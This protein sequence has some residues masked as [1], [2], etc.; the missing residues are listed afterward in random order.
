M[1]DQDVEFGLVLPFDSDHPEFTRGFEC[2]QLWQ[3]MT[4]GEDIHDQL[5]HASNA[6]MVMRMAEALDYNFR[7]EAADEEWITLTLL[8]GEAPDAR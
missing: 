2:G 7:A 8:P 3:R 6:E 4:A 5:A 1:S